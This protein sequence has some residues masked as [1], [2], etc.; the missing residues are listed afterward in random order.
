MNSAKL[1]PTSTVLVVPLVLDQDEVRMVLT[2]R[3]DH[4]RPT[5]S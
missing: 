2:E 5:S 4:Y 1:R 3:G